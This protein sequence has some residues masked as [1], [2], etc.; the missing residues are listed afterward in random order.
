MRRVGQALKEKLDE[1]AHARLIDRQQKQQEEEAALKA[2]EME[3]LQE[4]A[5]RREQAEQLRKKQ[6][7]ER[8]ALRFS[9]WVKQ[10]QGVSEEELVKV[11]YSQDFFFVSI[12]VCPP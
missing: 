8:I 1:T 2:I 9:L 12:H 10:M 4:E 3:E 7:A 5:L 11:F 6:Q